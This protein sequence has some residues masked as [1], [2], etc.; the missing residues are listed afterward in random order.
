VKAFWSRLG[1]Q[2]GVGL[3][4]V[5][6]LLIF[7]GWN[8][9]ASRNRVPAQF[10]YLLSGG[11]AGLS[12]VILGAALIVVQNQRADRAALQRT[13]GELRE[14]L[15]RMR[16]SGNGQV[17][18]T[19]IARAEAEA[20]GL[21]MAGRSSYHRPSCRLVDGRDQAGA[22]PVEEARQR[23]LSPCRVCRP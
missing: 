21:V 10:P 19:A 1:G 6:F 4:L 3:A 13:V 23:G 15:E 20:A 14:L 8:G 17:D 11:I 7:L 22:I 18:A 16:P 5:G 9:A 12:F 2:L